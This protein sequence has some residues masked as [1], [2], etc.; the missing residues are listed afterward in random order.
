[1]RKFILMSVLLATFYIPLAMAHQA[2]LQKGIRVLRKRFLWYCIAYVIA[3]V[4]VI[5]RI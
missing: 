4:Y 1:V 3:V 2:D 5:P